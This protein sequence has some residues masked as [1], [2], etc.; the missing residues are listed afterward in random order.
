MLQ[1]HVEE[2]VRYVY[3]TRNNSSLKEYKASSDTISKAN[4]ESCGIDQDYHPLSDEDFH[5]E[6]MDIFSQFDRYLKG[7]DRTVNGSSVCNTVSNVRRILV[8][9]GVLDLTYFSKNFVD[10]FRDEYL[11]GSCIE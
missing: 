7:P 5:V 2:Q 10:L 11:G 1:P 6:M 4:S 8:M 3:D 9:L